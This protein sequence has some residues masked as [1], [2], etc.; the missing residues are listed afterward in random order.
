MDGKPTIAFGPLTKPGSGKHVWKISVELERLDQLGLV[1]GFTHPETIEHIGDTVVHVISIGINNELLS[2]PEEIQAHP[3]PK[4][5]ERVNLMAG[6]A[7]LHELVHA[8][9]MI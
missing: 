1:R 8:R 2:W 4:V 6:E 5:Q 9:I 3:N 7:L